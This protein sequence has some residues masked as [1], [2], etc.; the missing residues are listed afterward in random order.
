MVKLYCQYYFSYFWNR[1]YIYIKTFSL[2]FKNPSNFSVFG[3]WRAKKG[4]CDEKTFYSVTVPLLHQDYNLRNAYGLEPYDDLKGILRGTKGALAELDFV[5]EYKS[6]CYESD[7]QIKFLRKFRNYQVELVSYFNYNLAKINFYVW[8]IEEWLSY[9]PL[10]VPTDDAILRQEFEDDIFIVKILWSLLRPRAGRFQP[11]L[12]AFQ[13]YA[14]CSSYWVPGADLQ[15]WDLANFVELFAGSMNFTGIFDRILF[16]SNLFLPD[17]VRRTNI[18]SPYRKLNDYFLTRS[19][20]SDEQF[21]AFRR[22]M[23]KI[24]YKIE[25]VERQLVDYRFISPVVIMPAEK[26]YRIY[27]NFSEFDHNSY[28]FCLVTSY[29]ENEEADKFFIF[30]VYLDHIFSKYADKILN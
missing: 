23:Y 13:G 21:A 1:I 6:Y 18:S 9:F 3:I 10:L 5:L 19:N 27:K 28:G 29:I 4:F 17:S 26:M 15:T 12:S 22:S 2:F 11:P 14:F 25:S 8:E 30:E 7:V 24:C 16:F 20:Y